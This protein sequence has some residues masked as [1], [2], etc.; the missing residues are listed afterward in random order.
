MKLLAR[1]K[2]WFFLYILLISLISTFFYLNF[3]KELKIQETKELKEF[4]YKL[5]VALSNFE[6]LAKLSFEQLVNNEETLQLYKKIYSSNKEE[7]IAL[8]KKLFKRLNSSYQDLKIFGVRQFHFHLKDGESFIRFHK[9]KKFGDKLF[10]IRQTVKDANENSKFVKGFEEGRIFNGFRYVFPLNYKNEHLG[11][12]EIATSFNGIEKSLN[13]IYQQHYTFLIR[14]NLVD[15]KVFGEQKNQYYELSSCNK[16]FYKEKIDISHEGHNKFEYIL[17]RV[18]SKYSNNIYSKM[19]NNSSFG[20]HILV[21]NNYYEAQFIPIENYSNNYSAYVISINKDTFYPKLVDEYKAYFIFSTIL[22]LIIL[23]SFIL[24][25]RSRLKVKL[26][27]QFSEQIFN[28]QSS[29]QLIYYNEEIFLVNNSLLSYF[30]CH[31]IYQFKNSYKCISELFEGESTK[32]YIGVQKYQDRISWMTKLLN[33]KNNIE[34][35]IK[36]KNDIFS[37]NI[38]TIFND[39]ERYELVVLTNI[40]ELINSKNILIKE[41]EK[42][43]SEVKKQNILLTKQSKLAAMG[44]MISMIAHQWRQPLNA[45][46]IIVQDYKEANSYE[47]I[48][49]QYLNSQEARALKLITHMST[50]IDDFR[51]YF[52]PEKEKAVVSASSLINKAIEFTAHSFKNSNITLIQGKEPLSIYNLYVYVNEVVQ[53]LLNILNNAK[54]A[55]NEKNISD[56]KVTIETTIDGDMF[57][58]S[59]ADNAG[60]IPEKNIEDIFNP[61]FSTKGKNGT[62]LGLYMAKMLIENSLDGKLFVFNNDEGAVFSIYLPLSMKKKKSKVKIPD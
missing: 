32:E 10:S 14:K 24:L 44:E 38:K 7:K 6:N 12:V 15:K 49:E 13:K 27:K 5:E 47:E 9:P 59:I 25:N 53:I 48:D 52:K 61:Y 39:K 30:K 36:I 51:N 37:I 54:D 26:Q 40:T 41:I 31:T 34:Y 55:L 62:G 29:L 46:S 2:Y 19:N 1:Y 20:E 28:T 35:K 23:V 18:C 57:L 16:N 21:N 56:K 33:N 22:T 58:I 60:G 50:T 3:T 45:L 11:T 8:R 4:K 43:V 17:N 42:A